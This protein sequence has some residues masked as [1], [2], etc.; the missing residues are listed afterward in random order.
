MITLIVALLY[1][2]AV[3]L[4]LSLLYV[5]GSIRWYWHMAAIGVAAVL[6]SIP[7]LAFQQ[8][9]TPMFDA[10]FGS[11]LSVLF[12]WGLGG[13]ACQSMHWRGRVHSHSHQDV[14]EMRLA[15]GPAPNR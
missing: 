10:L 11:F 1:G 15:I 9:Q 6:G 13:A 3:V 14:R 12:L 7:Y 8:W 2:V 4:A 5:F